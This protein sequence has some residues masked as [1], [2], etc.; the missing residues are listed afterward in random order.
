V[1]PRDLLGF[2]FRRTRLARRADALHRKG[3]FDRALPLAIEVVDLARQ[4]L[5]EGHPRYA[6]SLNNLAMLYRDM[7]DFAQ[8]EPIYRQALK[9]LRVA[10]GEETRHD[11]A[12]ALNN[13]AELYW[14]MADYA[15]AEP[16]YRKALEVLRVAVGERHS[17]YATN[18][19][20]LAA[21]YSAMG[22]YARAEPL[23]REAVEIMR[24]TVGEKDPEYALRLNNLATVY[25]ATGDYARAEPVYRKALKIW[26]AA[27]E[28]NH[29]DYASTLNNLAELHRAMGDN[30]R[31]EPLYR[32]ALE[33]QRLVVGEKHPDYARSLTN[34]A[35]LYVATGRESEALISMMEAEAV[36]DWV[37]GQVFSIGSDSGRLSYLR[38]LEGSFGAFLSL[39]SQRLSN[40]QAARL[41]GF[42]L[43]L[44]RKGIDA[45]ALAAQRDAV[46]SG[47]YPHL[48]EGLRRLNVLRM[49]IAQK[50][51]AGPGPEGIEAHR[52]LLAWWSGEMD[53]MEGELAQQ[54]PEMNVERQ[55]RAA[56][57]RAIAPAL[58]DSSALVEFVRFQVFD[59]D[60]VPVHGGSRWKPARYLAFVSFSNQPD[61]VHMVDLGEAEPI[62]EMIAAFRASLTDSGR[63]LMVVGERPVTP[64]A[65]GV[66]LRAAVFDPLLSALGEC[67]RLFLS[68]DSGLTRLPFEALPALDGGHLIDSYRISYLSAGRDVLR[69][70]VASLGELGAPLVA[71]DPDF[72]LVG[73]D[74]ATAMDDN[75]VSVPVSRDL[76]RSGL[77][78]RRLP[79]TR[80]EGERVASLLGVRP[81]L[82]GAALEGRLKACLSPRILHI[83]THGFF[84]ED[85]AHDRTG[86]VAP[87][88]EGQIGGGVFGRLSH[89]RENPLL[90]SGLALAGANTWLEGRSLPPEAE[91][92]ILTA[93]DV[94][95]LDL[96]STDLVVLS[97]CET[98]LG[99]AKAGEGVVGL[100]RAIVLAGA[101]TLVMSL[102]K[103]P[104]QQ[105]QELMVDFYKRIHEGESR[106]EA[107]RQA[108]LALKERY[109]EPLYW[110]AFICQGDPGPLPA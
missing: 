72:D 59:F 32:K 89:A 17:D 85:Q 29:S 81:W 88:P 70:G 10:G 82:D 19:N 2:L 91:D 41:A 25:S 54:I 9:I 49:E 13:L 99:E 60:A 67:D 48:E 21:L 50:T 96:L 27:G 73:V 57:R 83:A 63:D 53:R 15:R 66:A 20:N 51:L 18:L 94:S 35:L 78:F 52:S 4:D 62:E 106:A 65:D 92:G 98:G 105:T 16:L 38:A 90:R 103:V 34:L 5:G 100:R 36:H 30:A 71:G 107:L 46:L 84:L 6:T 74:G 3:R 28:E 95:G 23:S 24:V 43:V 104:D 47:R 14:T 80:L 22:D 37:I 12:K 77:R 110:G 64:S 108:Q 26:R 55:L 40:S 1:T 56:D 97:A 102:W 93:A 39:V 8:A 7:G 75:R 87:G 79:G 101:K 76:N 58:P 31:A 42:D 69:F 68:A 109:A 44:R 86:T 45:E 33:I 61:D 11:Y